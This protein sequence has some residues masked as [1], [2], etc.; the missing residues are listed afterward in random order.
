MTPS[1]NPFA[2]NQQ[3]VFGYATHSSIERGDNMDKKD[4]KK[5]K[6][7]K[8]HGDPIASVEGM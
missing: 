4:E 5:E 3:K 8:V 2:H 7:G 6:K 1:P